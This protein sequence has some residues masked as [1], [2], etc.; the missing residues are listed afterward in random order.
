MAKSCC[1]IKVLGMKE[2]SGKLDNLN[3]SLNRKIIK[4]ALIKAATP[5]VKS[6][7]NNLKGVLSGNTRRAGGRPPGNLA[8]SLKGVKPK[9]YRKYASGKSLVVIGPSWPLGAHA[10]LLEYGKHNQPA[11]PWFR[12]AWDANKET[13]RQ[14]I[15]K[16]ISEQ[17]HRETK[18]GNIK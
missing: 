11:R 10:H 15:R 1:E 2:L 6:A 5:V 7:R 16:T 17:L 14:I 18:K 9:K 13:V 12:P 8:E 3:G 4:S